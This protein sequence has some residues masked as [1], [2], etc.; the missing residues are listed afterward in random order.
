MGTTISYASFNERNKPIIKNTVA[1]CASNSVVAFI[2]GFAVFTVIGYLI[3]IGS[4][5]SDRVQ[6]IGLAFI[7]YPAA[8]D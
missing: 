8:V 5:V 6:S 2:S 4:P 1:I 3:T 7:S